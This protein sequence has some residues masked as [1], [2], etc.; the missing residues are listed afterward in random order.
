[1]QDIRS[2]NFW[3]RPFLVIWETTHA[4]DLAC[5]HCRASAE[6]EALPGELNHEEARE[7]IRQ[8]RDMG[9]PI[10]IFSGG[11]PLKRGDLAGLVRHAKSVGLRT[12]AI[13]AASPLLTKEKVLELSRAGLDQVAFS[14]DADNAEEHDAF[15]KTAGAFQRTLGAIRE[16]QEAGLA[17]QVNSLVNLHNLEQFDRLIHFIRQLGIV[18]WEVFFLVPTGRGI[19][20][21]VIAAAKFEEAFEKIYQL[22]RT[23]PFVIKV[24]EAQHYRRFCIEKELQKKGI[25]AS[26]LDPSALELPDYLRRA[27]GPRQSMGH[28]PSGVNSGKGFLF[29]SCQGNIFPSG[30][31]PVSAGNVRTQ[32]LESTYRTSPVFLKLRDA[33]LLK[34]RCGICPYREICGGSRSRAY[35]MTGDYLAEDPCCAYVPAEKP[36]EIPDARSRISRENEGH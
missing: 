16:A 11:D 8:V 17:V 19:D 33:S 31:L 29:V 9:T 22:N 14:L 24:T 5:I 12:G 3:E 4:C 1:M 32:S 35:A 28:A 20:L 6:P 27:S 26:G 34:G 15:R 18:F 21:S 13:P 25:S 23:A 10:F 2:F 30:F 7:L 36:K